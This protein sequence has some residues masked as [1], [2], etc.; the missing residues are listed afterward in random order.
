M[1]LYTQNIQQHNDIQH[2]IAERFD[3][4]DIYTKSS[5]TT[6][7]TIHFYHNH[8]NHLRHR[9][10]DYV[11]NNTTTTTT[12]S[13]TPQF[14]IVHVYRVCARATS[15]NPASTTTASSATCEKK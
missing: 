11:S 4:H 3:L 6:T 10:H 8:Q 12:I 9:L 15:R 14:D 13:P 7:T 1:C 5:T 2:I